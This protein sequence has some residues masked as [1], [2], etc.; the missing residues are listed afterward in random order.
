MRCGIVSTHNSF[1][2]RMRGIKTRRH[3]NPTS[4]FTLQSWCWLSNY[5][6]F[7]FCRLLINDEMGRMDDSGNFHT[8]AKLTKVVVHLNYI[9]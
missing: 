8:K 9:F 2:L 1:S 4:R 3:L 7:Q 5:R 6:H